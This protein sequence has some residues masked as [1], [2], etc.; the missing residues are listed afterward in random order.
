MSEQ[1]KEGLWLHKQ[2][3]ELF[4]ELK[5][6]AVV[7]EEYDKPIELKNERH[8]RRVNQREF[9]AQFIKL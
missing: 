8:S 4:H 6:F 3:G 1:H 9:E 7:D 5:T 2:S